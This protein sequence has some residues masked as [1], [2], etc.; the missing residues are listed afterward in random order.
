VVSQTKIK[1]CLKLNIFCTTSASSGVEIK[2]NFFTPDGALVVRNRL[3]VIQSFVK[4][5]S[6]T[7]LRY[8]NMFR[9]APSPSSLQFTV[10]KLRL[11]PLALMSRIL[12]FDRNNTKETRI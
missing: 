3:S 9:L 1:F 8:F 10:I 4:P 7:L 12:N 2:V 5:H 11:K 6:D